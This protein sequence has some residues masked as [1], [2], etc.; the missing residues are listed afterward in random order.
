MELNTLFSPKKIGNVQIKN[1]IV[2]SATQIAG[3]SDDGHVTD[4]L[5][6]YYEE[7]AKGG[8]GLIITEITS[9]DEEGKNM[10]RRQ[11]CLYD[12]I[13]IAGN[14]KLVDAVHEYSDVKI[15][16]QLSH[17][18]RQGTRPVAPS[19]YTHKYNKKVA[20]VLSSEDIE[21]VVKNFADAGRR[22]YES[23]YDMIQLQAG[24]GWLLSSFLSPYL[25]KRT[26]EYGGSVEGRTKILVDIYNQTRDQVGKEFPIFLKLQTLDFVPDGLTLEEAEQMT[27]ILI[28]TGY[29]AIEP[30]GG[31]S[32]TILDP[33]Y[34]TYPFVVFDSAEN[35]NYF[36]GSVKR[37]KPLMKDRPVILMGGVR[38]PETIEKFLQ[39]E[40]TDFI[41]MCRPLI[42]EPDLPNRWES[43]DIS[44]PLCTSCNQCLMTSRA[45]IIFCPL[46]KKAERKK[47]R[48][49]EKQDQ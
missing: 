39:E 4:D 17:A 8:T 40:V 21:G 49:Q 28:D 47:K 1:R 20:R 43:G 44:L 38:N 24:H 9:I 34:P 14:K 42:W 46:K 12:D 15:A 30:A 7:V 48:E 41:S 33:A 16:P 25:N 22:A 5:I 18:G 11:V 13:Y 6:K 29:D 26:D 27:K 45:G 35:E 19:P 2:R 23:G 32:D 36:L 31:S 3:A 10:S 37:L